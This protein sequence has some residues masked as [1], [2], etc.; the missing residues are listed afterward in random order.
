M[1]APRIGAAID[2]ADLA[3]WGEWIVKDHRDL[4]LQDFCDPEVISGD[5]HPLVEEA[6]RRLDGHEGRY[7]PSCQVLSANQVSRAFGGHHGH[8]YALWWE[9]LRVE[10][11]EAVGKQK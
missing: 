3:Q 10:D 9:D 7:T 6:R 2:V 11:T 1:P 8:I 4:E 5:W